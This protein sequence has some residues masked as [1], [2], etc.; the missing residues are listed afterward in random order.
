MQA[1]TPPLPPPSLGPCGKIS[2]PTTLTGESRSVLE[3][4][5]LN[6][7][8]YRPFRT[9][10]L[11]NF[12]GNSSWFVWSAGFGWYVQGLTNSPA[13]VGFAFFVSGL[14]FLLLTLHAG[15]LTDRF[16]ARPLVAI[17]FGLTGGVMFA[18]GALALVPNVPLWLVLL[19]A[20]VC[21]VTQ[22]L[23]APG[24]VSIVNDLVPPGEV[25][26]AVALNFLGISIGRICGGIIGGILIA[27]WPAGWALIV[28]AALQAA[29][30]IFIWRL[31]TPPPDRTVKHEGSLLGP[32]LEA[33]RYGVSNPSLGVLLLLAMAPGMIGLSYNY[34][35]PAAA[36]QLG[37]GGDGL[38]L[39]L[40]TAGVGGLISGLTAERFMRSVGH[41]KMVFLGLATSASGMVAFGI[42]PVPALAVLAMGFVGGGFLVYAA[43]SLSLVQALSPARLRGRLTGLFTLLYW[44]M[45][46]IGGL[47]LGS[48]AQVTSARFA[49]AAAGATIIVCAALAVLVRRQII[50]LRVGRDG[51]TV[52]TEVAVNLAA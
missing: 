12:M 42:A 39:L 48:L 3:R 45:M 24:Y 18:L 27:T 4:M 11:A 1:G 26:S 20:L 22:T 37:I 13:T 51:A 9:F 28:A 8:A 43:A 19:L 49:I 14:P 6:A 40:A 10:F 47:L 34:V 32:L 46:P 29:P 2:R 15:L 30:A 17:S 16:G 21:G 25:S 7:L 44:G 50:V 41:G 31:K 23:G 5:A 52:A 33:A 35:L 38:G 36:Q